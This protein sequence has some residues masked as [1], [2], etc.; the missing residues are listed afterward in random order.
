MC[1]TVVVYILSISRHPSDVK[2]IVSVFHPPVCSV[3]N[4]FI[5]T[6]ALAPC[7][8]LVIINESKSLGNGLTLWKLA[9]KITPVISA[10]WS[11]YPFHVPS[12]IVLRL[13]CMITSIQRIDGT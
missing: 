4:S 11:S 6:T 9:F 12:H 7:R 10:S 8:Y 13:V 2:E 1:R 3:P 5:S